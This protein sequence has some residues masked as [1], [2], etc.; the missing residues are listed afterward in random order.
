MLKRF[1]E[2]VDACI[3]SEKKVNLNISI[4][5]YDQKNFF[6]TEKK[7]SCTRKVYASLPSIYSF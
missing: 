5:V 1:L 7:V 4:F 3:I 6:S 2:N